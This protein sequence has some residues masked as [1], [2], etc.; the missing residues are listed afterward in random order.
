LGG[1]AAQI[2]LVPV[3]EPRLVPGPDGTA[4]P[5]ELPPAPATRR[6][7]VA[8]DGTFRLDDELPLGP[9][10]LTVSSPG[11]SALVERVRG[12]IDGAT[13]RRL[14]LVY[15]AAEISGQVWRR[16][17]EPA[18]GSAVT[19][20]PKSGAGRREST[21][22]YRTTT[23]SSGAYV[24]RGLIAGSYEV[25]ATFGDG[26]IDGPALKGTAV[27]AADRP[28]VLDLGSPT[29]RARLRGVLRTRDGSVITRK[30]ARLL[31]TASDA[32]GPEAAEVWLDGAFVVWLE[33]GRYTVQVSEPLGA[34]PLGPID[35]LRPE[36]AEQD[37]QLTGSIVRGRV[38]ARSAGVPRGERSVRR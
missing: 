18:A 2:E 27:T 9:W 38:T 12:A 6:L 17:G 36:P 3:R 34:W 13:V 37:L 14:V 16:T 19:A 4:V 30:G 24:F 11:R 32:E 28:G 5:Q 26:R 7:E 20:V 15:G 31:W 10:E 33:P 23:D 21:A 1:A 22:V 29:P 35:V 25:R 8:S